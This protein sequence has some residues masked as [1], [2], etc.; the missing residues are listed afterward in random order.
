M[1]PLKKTEETEAG[2]A[3]KRTHSKKAAPVVDPVAAAAETAPEA[4]TAV[5]GEDA[6]VAGQPEERADDAAGY[7]PET[8]VAIDQMVAF[9]LGDQR[10]ALPI[11]SVQEIQQIVAFAQAPA[12][13][14]AVVGMLNLRGQVIPA[15][16][17]RTLIG[18]PKEEYRLDTPMVICRTGDHLVALVVDEVEDVLDLPRHMLAP[19]PK[20]HSLSDRM[21]GVVHL[22]TELVFLLDVDLLVGPLGL[23]GAGGW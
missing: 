15:I 10:Y 17:L 9:H 12:S 6:P 2:T 1:S 4:P 23:D 11:G 8:S 18:M 21:I 19:P 7:T 16:D 13:S 3:P 14:H 22:D 5:A 20:L